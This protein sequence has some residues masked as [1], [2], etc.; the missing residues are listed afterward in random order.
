M[1]NLWLILIG[2]I[3][4]L[5]GSIPATEYRLKGEFEWNRHKVFSVLGSQIV[6][7][8]IG[9]ALC[10]IPIYLLAPRAFLFLLPGIL[11]AFPRHISRFRAYLQELKTYVGNA[12]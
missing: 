11:L 10:L 6:G 9:L 4:Y 5:V 1:A 8:V 3:T 2:G 7:R 12:S